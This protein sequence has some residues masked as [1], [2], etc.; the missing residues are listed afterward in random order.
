M[1]QIKRL[2]PLQ[3]P[4]LGPGRYADGGNLVF[5]V[6]PSG[7]KSWIFRYAIAGKEKVM[8]LGGF[9][10][11]SLAKARAKA[12]SARELLVE[13][14]DPL[15]HREAVRLKAR[16]AAAQTITFREAA[17]ACIAARAETWSAK[18]LQQ[19][20]QSLEDFVFPA[21]GSLPVNEIALQHVLQVLEPLWKSKPQTGMRVR[22]RIEV[23][24]NWSTIRQYRT[25]E[26]PAR[27][28][29]FLEELL[30]QVATVEHMAAPPYSD[31]PGLMR[32]L[33]EVEGVAARSLEFLILSAARHGEIRGARWSEIDREKRIWTIPADRMKARREHRLPLSAPMMAI[34]DKLHRERCSDFVFPGF[35]GGQPL[36]FKALA[37]LLGRIGV[38]N[39][40]VH[41]FRSA[42]RSWAAEETSFPSEIAELQ[43]SHQ[44]G[45]SLERA[46]QRSDLFVRRVE[47][48]EA[49]GSYC[50][51]AVPAEVVPLRRV[52]R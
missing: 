31:V 14:V 7:S 2:K 27:W 49:W 18:H 20:E 25:G 36:A 39:V 50:C 34:L 48:A 33:R 1:R 13:G 29:G 45:T 51:G 22:G 47:L 43:L 6:G 9:P 41:G 16:L 15:E 37:R 28:K 40:T 17:V 46:Y 30:P 24:L 44:V 12:Q 4:G 8:G 11:I 52:A 38:G 19:W 32:Q 26:N 21:I 5:Q 42:F 35:R 23:I 3:L 10:V